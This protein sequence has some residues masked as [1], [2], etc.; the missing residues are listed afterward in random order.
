[1]KADA[2]KIIL[3]LS[4]AI[5]AGAFLLTGSLDLSTASGNSGVTGYFFAA[6]TFQPSGDGKDTYL[7]SGSPNQNYGA[8]V[9][10]DIKGDDNR[11]VLM[12]FDLSGIPA[13]SIIK[14]ATLTLYVISTGAPP[15][16]VVNVTRVTRAWDEGTGTGSITKDG[17][18]WDNATGNNKWTTSGGDFD[19]KIWATTTITGANRYYSWDV[20]ELVRS[21]A[22]GTYSN[23]GMLIRT[24]TTSS[25]TT[26]FA[27]S[28][29]TNASRRPNLTVTYVT[30]PTW[31]NQGQN[32]ST[33]SVGG[34]VGISVFWDDNS[35]LKYAWLATNETGSWRNKTSYGSPVLINAASGWSNFSWQ[36]SSLGGGAAVG[37]KV[38]MNNS[39]G[40][41]N[42]TNIMTFTMVAP[43]DNPP[44]WSNVQ[45]S[46]P[47]SY[48]GTTSSTFSVTWT[49][50]N[51]MAGVL[52]ESNY[53]GTARNYTMPGSGIYSYSA[54]LPAGA[55]YWKSHA[56][57]T[58]GKSNSTPASTFAI[59]K[60]PPSIIITLDGQQAD[61]TV[62]EGSTVN[63]T[64][65][66]IAP[67]SGNLNLT[68]DGTTITSGPSPLQNLSLFSNAGTFL[69]NAN[70]AGNNNY[71]AGST[72]RNVTV[73]S[74]T[75]NGTTPL[76]QQA[77]IVQPGPDECMRCPSATDWSACLD[78]KQTRT[79]NDCDRTTAYRCL[80]RDEQS[81]C[82]SPIPPITQET[83]PTQTAKQTTGN[84][85]N[86]TAATAPLAAVTGMV[87]S[88]PGLLPITGLAIAVGGA[89]IWTNRTRRSSKKPDRKTD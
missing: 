71:T 62:D 83:Q 86:P 57:D 59:G 14:T 51:G 47:G 80:P 26:T 87:S 70:Y 7:V 79:V 48:S 63:I 6:G 75:V 11:R 5:T 49:D 81:T 18:T 53:S 10:M 21:W 52:L 58:G 66:L 13:N 54:I 29:N 41:E 1:M 24:D 60:A 25:G 69:I 37:W 45:A 68:M 73:N 67:P 84:E 34:T 30:P 61:L 82:E 42:A 20:A 23:Y 88:I 32:T 38:Y 12:E 77:I 76:R 22:N 9:D 64:A 19:S 55:F 28:D 44:V 8:S 56:N 2:D 78:G 43:P 39:D 31:A 16:P 15:N 3:F 33:P 74:V 36:N 85:N 65:S 4:I 50:D 89:M 35:T 46:V 72:S 17:A 40:L 27:S